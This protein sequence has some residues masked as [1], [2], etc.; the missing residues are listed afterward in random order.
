MG[1][2]HTSRAGSALL[3]VLVTGALAACGQSAAEGPGAS[4]ETAGVNSAGSFDS[5]A[6]LHSQLPEKYRSEPIVI[7]LDPTF[8]ALNSLKPGTKEFTGVNADLGKALA[9]PLGT[10]VELEPVP[11]EQIVVGVA[12]D[13]YDMSMSG[14][15]DTAERQKQVDFVDY[16]ETKQV[17]FTEKDNPKNISGAAGGACGFKISVVQGTPDEVVFKKMVEQCKSAGKPAPTQV[18]IDSVAASHLALESGRVDAVIRENSSKPSWPTS[19]MIELDYGQTTYLGAIFSKKNA[20]LRDA[21]QKAFQEIMDSGEY[22][23]I[24]AK[25]GYQPIAMK[26]PGLNLATATG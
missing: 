24:L 20:A 17:L 13:R 22:D 21:V 12:S 23:T 10:K 5:S 25:Y 11:F 18:A 9:K 15:S 3:A 26:S 14:V 6:K 8:A 2:K 4:T 1:K 7:A 16:F 19:D